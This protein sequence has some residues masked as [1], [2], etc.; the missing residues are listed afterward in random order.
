MEKERNHCFYSSSLWEEFFKGHFHNFKA[1]QLV[2]IKPVE[3]AQLCN[4]LFTHLSLQELLNLTNIFFSIKKKNSHWR[5][6]SPVRE[7]PQC[8]QKGTIVSQDY[9]QSKSKTLYK[10]LAQKHT[11]NAHTC[12][13]GSCSLLKTQESFIHQRSLMT[14]L[15][16]V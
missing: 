1:L 5:D 4:D 13:V 16:S 8:F 10:Q 7:G 12:V 14:A 11:T 6:V 9:G 15:S 3:M 2:S